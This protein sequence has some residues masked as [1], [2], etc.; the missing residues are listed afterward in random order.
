MPK[1]WVTLPIYC[2]RTAGGSFL[3]TEMNTIIVTLVV[4]LLLFYWAV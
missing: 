1:P 4:L 3:E 2:P